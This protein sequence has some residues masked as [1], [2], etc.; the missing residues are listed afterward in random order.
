MSYRNVGESYV[1]ARG[2]FNQPVDEPNFEVAD[3]EAPLLTNDMYRLSEQS[4]RRSVEM[5]FNALL[6]QRQIDQQKGRN[7]T[8]Q[9]WNSDLLTNVMGEILIDDKQCHYS[10]E[11]A[12]THMRLWYQQ[13]IDNSKETLYLRDFLID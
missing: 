7:K 6:D 3:L 13:Q 10:L 8:M 11:D 12:P 2:L 1:S 4:A 9:P 5:N